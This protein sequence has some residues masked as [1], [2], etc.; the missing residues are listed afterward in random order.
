MFSGSPAWICNLCADE[1]DEEEEEQAADAGHQTDD[2]DDGPDDVIQTYTGA[3][4]RAAKALCC[5]RCPKLK[6]GRWTG[7]IARFLGWDDHQAGH[8]T[9]LCSARIGNVV[10]Y[11]GAFPGCCL[12][13]TPVRCN[14]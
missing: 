1:A 9:S 6:R 14:A 12:A 5:V 10:A 2:D 8:A 4:V 3:Q 13:E 11:L 7:G